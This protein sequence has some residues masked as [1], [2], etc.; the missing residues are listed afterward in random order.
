MA[1]VLINESTLTDIGDVVR[2]AEGHEDLIPVVDMAYRLQVAIDNAAGWTPTSTGIT[3]TENGTYYPPDYEVEYFDEVIVNVPSSGGE[4]EY[5][6]DEDL[7]FSGYLSSNSLNGTISG[8]VLQKEMDRIQF[9]NIYEARYLFNGVGKLDLSSMTINLSNANIAAMFNG[10]SVVKLPRVT[11]SVSSAQQYPFGNC[12]NLTH[13]P[14]G[15]D[16]LDYS[17]L[18]ETQG[19]MESFFYGCRS[20][21]EIPAEVLRQLWNKGTEYILYRYTFSDC[22]S[23]TEVIG[24][25]VYENL[26]PYNQFDGTFDYCYCL[27]D[28]IFDTNPDGTPK[29]ANWSNQHIYLGKVGQ[30]TSFSTVPSWEESPFKEESVTYVS[31]DDDY[32]RLKNEKYWW[33]WD[34]YYSRY[35]HTSAVNTINSLPNV[36]GTNNIIDF[37]AWCSNRGS[38]TDGGAIGDLTEEEIAIA[39]NKG[40]T[41]AINSL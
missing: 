19:W 4:E 36:T 16:T 3:F 6:D 33:T 30:W 32:A 9:N 11:G 23:L 14:E 1:K 17:Q 34:E 28:V 8:K 40:W 5:F 10:A 22:F 18:H 39:A 12:Y 26:E 37:G 2:A 38:K 7:V 35:N 41:V 31:N 15:M 21:Q 27:K 24:L 25:P 13:L 20:L 29:T